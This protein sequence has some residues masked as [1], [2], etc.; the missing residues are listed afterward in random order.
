MTLGP[1]SAGTA[2][3]KDAG[4]TVSR[5]AS[6][7]LMAGVSLTASMMN[8]MSSAHAASASET[9]WPTLDGSRPLLLA[10]RGASA[11]RPEHTLAAYAKAIADGADYIEPDLVP[12]KDGALIVRHDP[13]ISQ[14]TDVSAH[15]EF[16][17]RRRRLAVDGQHMTGWFSTDFTL[18]EIKTLRARERLPQIRPQNA[19]YDGQFDIPTLQEVIDFV[20]AESA[21]RGRLIGIIPEIKHPTFFAGL[22]LPM[23]DRV[24]AVLGA[25]SYTRTAPLEIQCF[26]TGCLQKLRGKL[27]GAGVKARLIFLTG[28]PGEVPGDIQ[29]QGG[30]TTYGDLMKPAAL[31]EIRRYAEAIG[32]AN[33]SLIPRDPAGRWLEPTTLVRDAHAAG[34][35]VH[36]Y[37]CRPE[38][39]FLPAQLRNDAGPDARNEAGSIAEIRRYLAM[40]LDGF[41]TDDPAIGLRALNGN[42]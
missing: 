31:R 23:E 25:H 33:T 19:R 21:T 11:L 15:P 10:H 6:L 9:K 22:G 41:F 1:G 2:G 13:D 7:R 26:E 29:A 17:S 27:A 38:N 24:L 14:T 16:A 35:L 39:V 34:L 20:A 36:S 3:S 12:T 18:A 5:R 8:G 4:G 42:E 37:T 28:G 30:R 40:G 32:P